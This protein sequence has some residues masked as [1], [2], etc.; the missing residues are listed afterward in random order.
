MPDRLYHARHHPPTVGD[1][2]SAHWAE[3]VLSAMGAIRGLLGL[4]TEWAPYLTR[5]ENRLPPFYWTIVSI[6]LIIGGVI[7]LISIVKRLKTLNRFYLVLRTGL[8]LSALG[9]L[10]FFTSAIIVRPTHVFTWSYTLMS[11]VAVCGLYI[12]TF[13]N[14]RMIR[15]GEIEA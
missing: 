12:L 9:W 14:E 3:L 15:R 8:A 10:S 5:P 7:W 1:R 6:S 13:I 4:Y 11:A 2:I